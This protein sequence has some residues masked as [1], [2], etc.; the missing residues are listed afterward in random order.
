MRKNRAISAAAPGIQPPAG[1]GEVFPG[2]ADLFPAGAHHTVR[3]KVIGITADF[4]ESKRPRARFIQVIPFIRILFPAGDHCTGIL[5][6]IPVVFKIEM[7][8]SKLAQT[9]ANEAGAKVL[10]F[11]S[12]HNISADDF[13]TGTTYVDIMEQNLTVL[14]EA[15]Q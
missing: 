10:T 4:P 15:L 9:I 14:E 8:S 7:S 5:E 2:A 6:E 1:I 12:A 3:I 13:N 11:H